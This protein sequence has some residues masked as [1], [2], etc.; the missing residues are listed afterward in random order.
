MTIHLFQLI[1]FNSFIAIL[2]FQVIHDNSFASIHAFQFLH[3]K[4]FMS[5]NSCQFIHFMHF[6]S[7]Q[8]TSVQLTMKSQRPC[9]FF[10]TSAPARAGHHWYRYI[11]LSLYIYTLHVCVQNPGIKWQIVFISMDLLSLFGSRICP[12]EFCPVPPWLYVCLLSYVCVRI[13]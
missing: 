12:F 7:F 8:F 10:E 6:I 13:F 1:H 9:L 5:I 3:F 4:F 11:Y 2:S